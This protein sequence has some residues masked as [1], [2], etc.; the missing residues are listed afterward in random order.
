MS[1]DDEKPEADALSLSRS[2]QPTI[3]PTIATVIERRDFAPKP[4][5]VERQS[6]T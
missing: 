3:D 6:E 5:D 2:N 4:N 1:K